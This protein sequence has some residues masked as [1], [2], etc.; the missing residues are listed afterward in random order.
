MVDICYTISLS[1]K[2]S[3]IAYLMSTDTNK[4]T[5]IMTLESDKFYNLTLNND[6]PA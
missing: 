3:A 4:K 1:D 6:H 5:S 2:F